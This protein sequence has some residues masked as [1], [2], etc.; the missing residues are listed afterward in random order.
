MTRISGSRSRPP[1]HAIAPWTS[2]AKPRCP[3]AAAPRSDWEIL[4]HLDE[5]EAL[6]RI[7]R[8]DQQYVRVLSY[9]FRGPPKLAA[10]THEAFMQSIRVPAGYSVSDEY[11]DWQDDQSGKGLWRVFGMGLALVLLTVAMVFDSAWGAG[12]VFLSLPLALAGVVVAFWATGSAVTREAAVGVILVVGLAVH[13]AILLVDGVLVHRR[14]TGAGAADVG[15]HGRARVPA[16]PA[17][18]VLAASAR[19]RRHDHPDHL[20]HPRQS[21]SAR[22]GRRGATISSGRSHSRRRVALSPA[23]SARCSCSR[24]CWCDGASQRTLV[25]ANAPQGPFRTGC[26]RAPEASAGG[27]PI[28]YD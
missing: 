22:R 6:A 21:H 14:R 16:G 4:A 7:S 15:A 25:G 13:Q 26:P 5:R 2:C 3:I 10:R 23:R 18:T 1:A 11:F 28:R 20:H 12:M 27:A 17:A 24:R 9:D 8:E 19:P